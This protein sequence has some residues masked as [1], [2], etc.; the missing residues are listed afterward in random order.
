M[1]TLKRLRIRRPVALA[2][3]LTAAPTLGQSITGTVLDAAGNPVNGV[4]IDVDNLRGGGDPNVFNDGTS[5]TGTFDTTIE[6]NGVFDITFT[7]PPPPQTT[8]QPVRLRDV[9]VIG[10]TDLGTIVL[11]AGISVG[12]RLVNE[13]GL[14]VPNVNID[15]EDANGN[16]LIVS[17]DRSNAFGEFLVTAPPGGATVELLTA[18]SGQVLVS[19]EIPISATNNLDL[20]TITLETGFLITGRVVNP[21]ADVTGIDIDVFDT[22]TGE[23]LFTPGDNTG[24]GGLFSLTVPA[25]TFDLEWC[26]PLARR[27]VAQDVEGLVVNANTILPDVPLESGSILSGTVTLP[28]GMP[29]QGVDLDVSRVAGGSVVTCADDTNAAGFY[30]IVVPNTALSVEWTPQ[31]A[32]RFFEVARRNS[33]VISGD[34]IV[35]IVLPECGPCGGDLGEP[36]TAGGDLDVD[37]FFEETIL[38]GQG[39]SGTGGIAPTIR[40]EGTQPSVFNNDFRLFVENARGGSF[41]FLSSSIRPAMTPILDGFLLV[42]PFVPDLSRPILL[43]GAPGEPGAGSGEFLTGGIPPEL[44]GARIFAQFLVVDPVSPT[45]ATVS[46]GI[47]FRIRNSP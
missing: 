17:N 34:R 44:L 36:P 7:P 4:D 45:G 47:R 14:P 27:L 31:G 25:G 6:T 30:Q 2:L 18:T 10:A 37:V 16:N 40:F 39:V 9:V 42:E 12:G 46:N 43:S 15:I 24:L 22:Q 13:T 32:D 23:Q 26:P 21:G 5:P 28:N 33:L 11:P 20:G 19:Q 29:A 8:A 35:N 38:F 1:H 41:A 3:I